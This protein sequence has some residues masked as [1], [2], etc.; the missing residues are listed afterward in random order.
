MNCMWKGP[1]KCLPLSAAEAE[2][3]RRPLGVSE[4]VGGGKHS[5]A[6]RKPDAGLLVCHVR[7]A[8][9]S[10]GG[11]AKQGVSGYRS[12]PLIRSAK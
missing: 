3:I 7:R 1:H 10:F 5:L 9:M 2:H 6:V 4:L 11:S 12:A 8:V